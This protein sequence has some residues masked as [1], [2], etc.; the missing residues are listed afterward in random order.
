LVLNAALAIR[1]GLE[2]N[3]NFLF[4]DASL[5]EPVKKP[6]VTDFAAELFDPGKKFLAVAADSTEKTG[7]VAAVNTFT[8]DHDYLIAMASAHRLCNP[9][10]K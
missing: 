3:Q 7:A 10:L 1:I 8:A 6:A 2:K 4:G 9:S 5:F